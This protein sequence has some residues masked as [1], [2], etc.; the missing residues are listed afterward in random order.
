MMVEKMH[1][2]WSLISFWF[3]HSLSKKKIFRVQGDSGGA[4]H[5]E[6]P[7]GS[8]DIIGVVSWGRGCGKFIHVLIHNQLKLFNCRIPLAAR[9]NLPGI[10][11][12][13]VNYLPW[14]NK[15]LGSECLC[16]PK[17]TENSNSL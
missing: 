2:R 10:Y 6:G 12:K 7:T 4:M 16:S 15:K 3:K 5:K 14:I 13:V 11:T 1:A 9:P 8:M 17:N